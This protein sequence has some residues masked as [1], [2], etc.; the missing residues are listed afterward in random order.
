MMHNLSMKTCPRCKLEKPRTNEFFHR[1]SRSKDGLTSY[2][3]LC[4]CTNASDHCHR[5]PK[6][7]YEVSRKA[8]LLNHE[9]YLAYGRTYYI[10][11]KARLSGQNK[12]YAEEHKEG[13]TI[14]RRAYRQKNLE[15]IRAKD[16]E[17]YQT[18][19][20]K[21]LEYG[22]KQRK[23]DPARML[24]YQQ[25]YRSKNMDKV[26][27]LTRNHRARLRNATGT[28]SEIDIRRLL[29]FQQ[30]NCAYCRKSMEQNYT[31]DHRVPLI[32]GGSNAPVNLCLAC[33][34]C[35]SKKSGLTE[36]EYRLRI[37]AA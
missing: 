24:E 30:N 8:R 19:K 17:Y 9:K 11:N 16:K 32:R 23:K 7:A 33:L 1:N 36:Y 26:R 18:H 34:S 15:A 28:H 3:K 22:R 29:W 4:A 14:Q 20:D 35:N 21:F 6:K 10:P 5:D 27:S 12:K 2:C 31:V 13:I 25:R 37:K